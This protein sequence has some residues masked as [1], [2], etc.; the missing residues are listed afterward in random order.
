MYDYA[1]TFFVDKAKVKGS[2]QVNISKVHLYFRKKPKSG[3]GND[4]NK[5]GLVNPGV[6]VSIVPVKQDGTPNL[7]KVIESARLEYGQ[8]VTSGDAKSESVFVFE[9]TVYLDTDK[10]Y[11]LYIQFDGQEDFTLWTNKKGD[12]FVGTDKVSPG[13]NDKLV[14]NL[15]KTKDRLTADFDPD[16][17]GGVGSNQGVNDKASWV[18]MKNED[19]T[20]E[21]FCARYAAGDK[22]N[23]IK[24]M[25]DEFILFDTKHSKVDDRAHAGEKIFQLGP[26]AS[27]N[28]I[29]HTVKVERGNSTITSATANFEAIFVGSGDK[30]LILVSENQD[31]DHPSGDNNIYNVGKI[32]DIDGSTIVI[33]KLPTFTNSAAKFIV[34]PVGFV[35]FI[36]RTQ[37]FDA[38]GNSPSWD[39]GD[40]ARQDLL[41]LNKS[42]ANLT[43]RFVN[44]SIYSISVATEG[45]GYKNTDYVVVTSATGGSI[46]AYANVRTN[47]SGNLTTVY[48]TNAGAG[49]IDTPSVTVMNNSNLPAVGTGATFTLKEGPWLKSELKKFVFKDVEVIDFEIDAITPKMLKNTPAGSEFEIKHQVAYIKDDNGDYV[50]N[51][52]AEANQQLIKNLKKN[53][54]PYKK[55]AAL[56]SRSNELVQLA[57][58]SGNSTHLVT[59]TTTDND[60]IDNC[61]GGGTI[62]YH[63]YLINN[64][65]TNEHTSFGNAKAKHVTSRVSFAEGRL[66]E[67]AIVIV[68]AYRPPRTDL[69]VYTRLYNSQDPEAF[70]D[71]DWTLMECTS[72]EK[73][74]SSEKDDK[75]IREFTYNIP[76]YPKVS[77]VLDGYVTLT[78]GCTTV[79]GVGTEFKDELNGGVNG[80]L[81]MIYD[82]LFK[83]DKHF[84]VSINTISTDTSMVID[85]STTNT[86]LLGTT[87][88]MAKFKYKNQAF[89]N[90]SNDNVARYYNTSMHVFDGYD[91]MAIKVV[92]LSEKTKIIPEIEDIRA[93]GVSA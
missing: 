18:A 67:D 54:L 76:Q 73:E 58:V 44:N 74:F 24:T 61:D 59:K 45:S 47:A 3:G 14:G 31:V 11:A 88:K 29:A 37:A 69:K 1:Q 10:M 27:N 23:N 63:K 34:S 32:K 85:D 71:K 48:L 72:G 62:E 25:D 20:F 39:W 75:D 92:M 64:D 30:Y 78:S 83:E 36:D 6:D 42:N 82:P 86:S 21:V 38:K 26:Y 60:F 19:L 52:D 68:R 16:Q 79:T 87:L 65:Y 28:G 17:V 5:S 46:N 55:D 91:T 57:T 53:K 15:Y 41:I 35:D 93:I 7:S 84:I 66:A 50:I 81:V 2:P 8:I 33:N 77:H 49:M 4:A 40:R 70:D 56:I 90:I 13:E 12:T 89:R 43:N 9:K 51:Q 22:N 80:D